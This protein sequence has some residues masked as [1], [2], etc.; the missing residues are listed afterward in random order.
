MTRGVGD[1][2]PG[3]AQVADRRRPRVG[4]EAQEGDARAGEVE[5]GD[6]VVPAGLAHAPVGQRARRLCS[7]LSAVVEGVVVG[8]VDDVDAGGG[9]RH[10]VLRRRLE[11]KAR[12]AGVRHA[13]RAPAMAQR[14]FEV[15]RA[16]IGAAH[17]VRDARQ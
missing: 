8:G 16:N 10:G 5:V 6:G 11:G 3:R 9:E 2:C 4:G 12:R 14:A 17:E 13:L 7:A 15:H 1:Q